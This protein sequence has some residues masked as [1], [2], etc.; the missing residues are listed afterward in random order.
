MDTHV[1]L[2]ALPATNYITN[3]ELPD[4]S[5]VSQVNL[6]LVSP[7]HESPFLPSRPGWARRSL[8]IMTATI[9]SKLEPQSKVGI[10]K[11]NPIYA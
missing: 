3:S 8:S 2:P 5:I 1:G 4:R 11:K 9:E 7:R 6:L 10:D